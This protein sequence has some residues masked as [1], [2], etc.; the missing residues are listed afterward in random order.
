M[1]GKDEKK[2]E[3]QVSNLSTNQD[4]ASNVD[5]E[6][7]KD[8]GAVAKLVGQMDE[9][10]PKDF[11]EDEPLSI[12]I[13]S[14]RLIAS[15]IALLVVGFIALNWYTNVPT[16]SS[17]LL[18]RVVK[19]KPQRINRSNQGKII[20]LTGKL[21]SKSNL[22]DKSFLVSA[23]N[24]LVLERKVEMY[25]WIEERIGGKKGTKGGKYSYKKK[26]KPGRINSARFKNRK[27]HNNPKPSFNSMKWSSSKV[28]LGKYNGKPV[29]DQL[30]SR[31]TLKLS[32][33]LVKNRYKKMLRN[34][35]IY[36]RRHK[37]KKARVGD[38]R[39]SYQVLKPTTYSVIAKQGKGGSLL[40][41]KQKGKSSS[42][43]VRKGKR[44][45]NNMIPIK[46]GVKRYMTWVS[47][48]LGFI[49]LS[50]GLFCCLRP[51]IP[52][53][54][55]LPL[56][57]DVNST[58][59][60]FLSSIAALLLGGAIG[61]AVLLSSFWANTFIVISLLG[62]G[63][64]LLFWKQKLLASEKPSPLDDIKDEFKDIPA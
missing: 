62:G 58:V 24:P 16:G 50:I 11:G 35:F 17:T 36:V 5:I 28:K 9:I 30:S 22:N 7:P 23:G 12:F 20:H 21:T 56:V 33:K 13:D 2:V 10:T 31:Y 60:G 38:I 61:L 1:N 6:L 59:I 29:L 53:F 25:Q 48:G 64:Y 45:V 8:G 14:I 32:K 27:G 3:E 18:D 37:G 39:I 46:G 41:F 52:L 42:I 40:P 19:V 26:W 4:K 57:K 34:N 49:I 47:F 51:F 15:G 54:P 55:N 44:D 43:I 63:G